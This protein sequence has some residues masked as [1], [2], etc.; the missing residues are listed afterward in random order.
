M[1]VLY[2]IEVPKHTLESYHML[3]AR[4]VIELAENSDGICNIGLRGGHHV[5]KASY[6]RLVYGRIAG[7]FVGLHLVKF[8]CHWRSNWPGLVHSELRQDRPNVTLLMDVDRV[9]LPIAFDVDAEIEGD[10]PE[11][12]HPEPLLYLVLDLSNEVLVSNDKEVINIQ[13]HRSNDYV[14]ILIMKDEQSSVNR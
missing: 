7:F 4:V 11:I 13:N 5:H 6:H 1:P 8:H 10:T 12:M 9:M 14:L 3:I 2:G